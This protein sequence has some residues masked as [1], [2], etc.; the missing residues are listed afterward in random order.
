LGH[1]PLHTAAW[2]AANSQRLSERLVRLGGMGL[3]L[4][5]RL[6]GPWTDH[7]L[8]GQLGWAA[9]RGMSEDRLLTLGEE[10]VER[11][12]RPH[13]NP[14][15]LELMRRARQDGHRIVW[16]SDS[17]EPVL[18][19]LAREFSVDDLVCNHLELRDHKV[20]G[21]LMDP[22]VAGYMSGQWAA[23]YASDHQLNLSQSAAYGGTVQHSVLLSAIGKPCTVNPDRAMRSMAR[24]LNW[25]IVEGE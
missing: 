4:P 13:L 7:T 15:G 25:P 17:I 9:L 11:F 12:H 23:Q 16:V 22:I 3:S 14:S 6:P 20:T 24:N 1:G 2:F 18:R 5:F 19:P 10:Y 8:A 21:K